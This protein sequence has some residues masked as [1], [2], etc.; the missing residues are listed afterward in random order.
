[1]SLDGLHANGQL[2]ETS[3]CNQTH[4]RTAI[5]TNGTGKVVLVKA[6]DDVFQVYHKCGFHIVKL[7]YDKQFEPAV[8]EWKIKQVPI[9]NVNYYNAGE[10]VPRL[11]RNN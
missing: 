3:I 2:F 9:V 10:N 8:D 4:F 5:P 11:E 7:H 6:V 1:M